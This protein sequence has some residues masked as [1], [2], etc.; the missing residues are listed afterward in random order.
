[1]RP[2]FL[3]TEGCRVGCSG[4]EAKGLVHAYIFVGSQGAGTADAPFNGEWPP[5]PPA[6]QHMTAGEGY[7]PS[8]VSA[9]GVGVGWSGVR[10][11]GAG[12]GLRMMEDA[13]QMALLWLGCHV[14]ER[15]G[16]VACRHGSPN[17]G[18]PDEGR[19]V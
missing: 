1:M 9:A 17:P 7:S 8:Q 3:G 14:T 11:A 4:P 2:L 18:G 5:L 10:G 12:C 6:P 15:C 19:E 13:L 16:L